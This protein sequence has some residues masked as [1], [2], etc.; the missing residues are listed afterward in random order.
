MITVEMGQLNFQS[1]Q[2]PVTGP[3]RE[4]LKESMEIMGQTLHFSAVSIGNPHCVVLSQK[5]T[6]EEICRLGPL[7]ETDGRFPN[8]INVQFVNVIDRNNI[9]IEI[10]ERGAGYTLASGSSSCAAAGVA[11]K[12]DLCDQNILV[13]M[14]GGELQIELSPD[15]T[16]TMKGPATRV[17]EGEFN[18][19]IY[20]YE[21][22]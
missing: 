4:I 2:I 15:F 19:E 11:H 20:S 21:E 9:Q 17:F 16:V 5:P 7:I 8:R 13:S 18:R 3:S 1:D 14:P 22:P 10:W 12:L 6:R